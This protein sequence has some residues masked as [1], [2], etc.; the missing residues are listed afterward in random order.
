MARQAPPARTATASP[1]AGRRFARAV[2]SMFHDRS[3]PTTWPRGRRSA[4]SPVSR[5]LPQPASMARSSPR[6][7]SASEHLLAPTGLRARDFVIRS[8]VPFPRHEVPPAAKTAP[9]R[10]VYRSVIPA[11]PALGRRPRPQRRCGHAP[12][13]PRGARRG[14]LEADLQIP[15]PQVAPVAR[16]GRR[17]DA[18]I[19]PLAPRAGPGEP[20]RRRPR[21]LPH[22]PAPLP[23]WLRG[24]PAEGRA[25]A[26]TRRRRHHRAAGLHDGG[27]RAGPDRARR[28][29]P[30]STSCSIANGC[31]RCSIAPSPTSRADAEARDR[32]AMF[33]VFARYDLADAAH[34]SELRRDRMRRSACP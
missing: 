31:A 10:V 16:C 29:R 23:R 4:S 18:G 5:P 26:Q 33:E 30:M 8:G 7:S 17:R 14:L 27:G 34:A 19:L 22:L 28:S 2:C 9:D 13:G 3:M 11:H 24:E 21:P 12:R 6:R 1:C 25:P 15:A 32:Q 20:L